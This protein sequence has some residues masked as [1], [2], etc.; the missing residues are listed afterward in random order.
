MTQS[1]MCCALFCIKVMEILGKNWQQG[2][3]KSIPR[4][5]YTFLKKFH[6]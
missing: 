3:G 1:S 5:F 6:Q 2:G 4:I